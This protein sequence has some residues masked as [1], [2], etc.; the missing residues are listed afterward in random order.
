[1]VRD[2]A[3]LNKVE[4]LPWD[5]WGAMLEPEDPMTQFEFDRFDHLADLMLDPDRNLRQLRR[6]YE[7]DGMRMPGEVFNAN[8]QLR[9]RV[10]RIAF[11]AGA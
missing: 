8:L 3:S 7:Q 6:V 10:S 2:L 1:M 5:V 9:E 4:M 11:A